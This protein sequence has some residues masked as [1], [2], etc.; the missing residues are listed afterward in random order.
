MASLCCFHTSLLLAAFMVTFSLGLGQ[1][2]HHQT[3]KLVLKYHQLI[4]HLAPTGNIQ[5]PNDNIQ[6]P[7]DNIHISIFYIQNFFAYSSE[8]GKI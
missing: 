2:C 4:S 8:S 7:D 6:A 3:S 1:K 5:V